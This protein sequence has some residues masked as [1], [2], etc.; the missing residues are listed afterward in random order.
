MKKRVLVFFVGL[1]C[2]Q[3]LSSAGNLSPVIVSLTQSEKDQFIRQVRHDLDDKTDHYTAAKIK[4]KTL[5]VKW[6]TAKCLQHK[7][8]RA[9]KAV[10]GICEVEIH[11]DKERIV[12]SL[13]KELEGIQADIMYIDVPPAKAATFSWF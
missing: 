10:M 13:T 4:E 7:E 11:T 5:T 1:I 9:P 3:S 2:G 6:N 8:T 12:T